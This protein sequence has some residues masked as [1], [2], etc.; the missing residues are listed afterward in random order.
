M[1]GYG[2]NKERVK[3]LLK[4]VVFLFTGLSALLG[5]IIWLYTVI[6]NRSCLGSD[7]V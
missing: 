7:A 6:P 3:D 4:K 5:S 2:K 1:V